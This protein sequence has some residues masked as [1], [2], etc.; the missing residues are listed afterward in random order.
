VGRII[1]P[2]YGTWLRASQVVSRL[3]RGGWISAGGYKPG[4]FND[5]LLAATAKDH[6]HVIVTHNRA[7]FE[8]IGRVLTGVRTA[9]PYP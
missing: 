1:I 7:D 4:F 9:P 6:G 8:L 5:C 2:E 3:V